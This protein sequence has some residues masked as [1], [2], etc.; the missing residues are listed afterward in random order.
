[1]GEGRI[2]TRLAQL[3]LTRDEPTGSISSP[4][5][6]ATVY[7]HPALGE[8]T[9]YDYARTGNPTRHVLEE[10][11]A[12][13]E[14]GV[15]GFAFSSGMAAIQAALSLFS[16]GDHL[17]VSMDL[18]GG[19]YRLLEHVLGKYGISASYVDTTSLERLEEARRPKTRGL[20]I[21]T[22]TNPQMLVTDLRAVCSWAREH[23]IWTIV[24]NTLM[25]PYY[26]RPLALGADVVVHSATKYLGGHND[27][28]AG[29]VVVRDEG[30]AEPLAFYQNTVGAVLSPFDAWLLLR[31]MK[32]LALRLARQSENAQRLAEYLAAHPL[33]SAVYYTGL[34]NHPG[35]DVHLRQADGHG[36]LLSFRVV[37]ARLV[38]PV[39]RSIQVI[40]FAES[41]GGV[42]TLMT[43]PEAQTHA[44]VPEEMR[45]RIGVDDT[46]LR[47]AVGIEHADD[48]LADLEQAL[49]AAAEEVGLT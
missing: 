3:G 18:Y 29:L 27:V 46:L 4:I 42:E 33:V 23:D 11:I 30:L 9:G 37:D 17:L 26:Q 7:R 5:Y 1:M 10:E 41:L 49:A 24:D 44:D 20:L 16:P 35:R 31:G 43:F 38:A 8:S 15:R 22:P 48:L 28:L 2:E 45:N 39:L 14:G 21:E 19:T 40:S 36:G 34:P 25:T 13:L 6:L 12:R 32:T 47:I